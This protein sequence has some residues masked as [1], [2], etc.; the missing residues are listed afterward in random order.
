M[1]LEQEKVARV[2]EGGGL[3]EKKSQ[4]G[5]V[6]VCVICAASFS[7]KYKLYSVLAGGKKEFM[8]IACVRVR[9]CFLSIPVHPS[10]FSPG[11]LSAAF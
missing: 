5:C 11:V 6:H 3:W 1:R 8:T 10:L 9:V 2:Q 7:W 4:C